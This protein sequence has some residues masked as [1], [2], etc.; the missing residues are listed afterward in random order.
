MSAE[1]LTQGFYQIYI[2]ISLFYA[3]GYLRTF[4]ENDALEYLNYLDELGNL[5]GELIF[6]TSVEY[7]KLQC[8]I[9]VH[10]NEDLMGRM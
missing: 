3:N 7:G 8:H 2:K 5:L 4:A 10:T 6:A 1:Y 9:Y